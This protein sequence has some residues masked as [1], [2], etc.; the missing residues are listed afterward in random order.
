MEKNTI[1]HYGQLV[2]V[3][4]ILSLLIS[5]AT[6]FVTVIKKS[7][8]GTVNNF[9]G[10]MNDS[11]LDNSKNPNSENNDNFETNLIPGLYSPNK[12]VLMSSWDNLLDSE[13]VQVDNGWFYCWGSSY[14]L[15]L[16]Q[17]EKN[18]Y[19]FYYGLQYTDGYG[20]IV[21]YEDGSY[22]EFFDDVVTHNPAGS[23]T[24]SHGCI[25]MPSMWFETIDVSSD[26]L[27]LFFEE[28]FLMELDLTPAVFGYLILPSDGSIMSVGDS[29]CGYQKGLTGIE[30][31]GSVTNIEYAAFW[32]ASNITE[33][34][35]HDGVLSIHENAFYGCS[36][37]THL[38]LPDTIMDIC[39]AVF[40]GCKNLTGTIYDNAIYLGNDDNPYAVLWK[41]V[42]RDITSC[43]INE[44][45]K[46][47]AP[48][49][50][51]DCDNLVEIS[52][53]SGL[54]NI[55]F[56]AFSGTDLATTSYDNALYLGNND[57]PYLVLLGVIDYSITSCVINE[58][59]KIIYSYA[60]DG[61]S[62]LTNI[63]IPDGV[64]SIGDRAF[65]DC[66]N[67]ASV[68]ISSSVI[69][70]DDRAFYN[71]DSVTSIVIPDNVVRMGE[72]IFSFCNNLQYVKIGC[73]VKT[74]GLYTFEYCDNLTTVELSDGLLHIGNAVFSNCSNLTSIVIPK[75]IMY[76]NP[77]IFNTCENLI[78]VIFD[79]TIAEWNSVGKSSFWAY[80][81][82]V[83]C[84]Q[85]S[86]GQVFVTQE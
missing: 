34:I 18:E 15:Q 70:I 58:N 45:T 78:E 74:L 63:V 35:I 44:T 5:L 3:V 59:T 8:V 21:F 57:N 81:S 77:Y 72:A 20:C 85:C 52:L 80:G 6:P 53:P 7:V 84:V 76:I 43:E 86:D 82:V 25:A 10:Q 40:S 55:G 51:C 66:T 48:N 13:T 71:C 56:S 11:I 29:S 27:S 19:G 33:I 28:E 61:C 30:I 2:I 12:E 4:V 69:N 17:F 23:A 64:V 75:T 24:Y 46:Y 31:P 62:N 67:L 79:G 14:N 54:I 60:F 16:D 65:A 9:T 83:L 32:Y 41:A 50:F 38:S 68:E 37:L 39:F 73:G 49:A 1:S 42:N 22:D 47:I 36:N 26:G